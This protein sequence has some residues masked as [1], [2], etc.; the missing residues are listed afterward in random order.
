MAAMSESRAEEPRS[1]SVERSKN[2]SIIA[3]RNF[4]SFLPVLFVSGIW[5]KVALPACRKKRE[6]S[7]AHFSL[8]EPESE[9]RVATA[10]C[11]ARQNDFRFECQTAKEGAS[12]RSRGAI[13]PE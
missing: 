2:Y 3:T 8:F 13:A 10:A 4:L 7:F 12:P 5:M 1:S 6:T 11:P 9:V